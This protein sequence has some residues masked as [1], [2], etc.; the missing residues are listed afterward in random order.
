MEAAGGS[1]ALAIA[2][3]A[4][5]HAVTQAHLAVTAVLGDVDILVNNAGTNARSATGPTCPPPTWPPWWT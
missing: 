2:D 5:A 4:D 1:A 3:V